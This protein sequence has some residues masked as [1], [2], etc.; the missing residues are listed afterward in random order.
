MSAL[1]LDMQLEFWTA[2]EPGV[3]RPEPEPDPE[4]PEAAP[5][6]A[7]SQ[8]APVGGEHTLEDVILGAWEGLV[9]HH[10]VSCPVCGGQMSPWVGAGPRGLSGRCGDCGTRLC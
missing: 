6:A 3:E 2:P 9:A 5:F 7:M 10:S 1:A 4:R 8:T